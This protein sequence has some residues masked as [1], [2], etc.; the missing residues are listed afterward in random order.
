MTQQY[1]LV[2][3]SL[4]LDYIFESSEIYTNILKDFFGNSLSLLFKGVIPLYIMKK[5]QI[6]MLLDTR[7]NEQKNTQSQSR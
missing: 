2:I 3:L 1:I 4:F 6:Q 5:K 7:K